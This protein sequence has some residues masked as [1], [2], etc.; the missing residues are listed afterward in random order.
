MDPFTALVLFYSPL[1]SHKFPQLFA[2]LGIV[3]HLQTHPR[4]ALNQ[5]KLTPFGNFDLSQAMHVRAFPEKRSSFGQK[6]R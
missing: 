3:Q 6:E 5:R 4:R 2:I 1:V